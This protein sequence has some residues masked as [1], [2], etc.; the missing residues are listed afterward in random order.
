MV[1]NYNN[2]IKAEQTNNISDYIKKYKYKNK[3]NFIPFFLGAGLFVNC[4]LKNNNLKKNIV[5][6]GTYNNYS[7]NKMF[8][9]NLLRESFFNNILEKLNTYGI[10][11]LDKNNYLKKDFFS[12]F[13][14]KFEIIKDNEKTKIITMEIINCSEEEKEQLYIRLLSSSLIYFHYFDIKQIDYLL[15]D[16][17][18]NNTTTIVSKIVG[19]NIY[20][21]NEKIDITKEEIEEFSANDFLEK[22][23]KNN[24]AE[25]SFL[26]KTC[27][28]FENCKTNI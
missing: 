26:C 18:H 16:Y 5:S 24:Q 8:K 2:I 15:F 11:I 12:L 9:I 10:I 1:L 21:N 4:P 6:I 25:K 19:N 22:I 13:E 3:V 20:F 14:E 17:Q 23:Q 27:E 7:L 28:Y